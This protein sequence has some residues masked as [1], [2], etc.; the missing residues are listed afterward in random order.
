MLNIIK[1]GTHLD[2]ADKYFREIFKTY[3]M[4]N[5]HRNYAY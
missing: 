5:I 3:F 2:D 1:E 4:H